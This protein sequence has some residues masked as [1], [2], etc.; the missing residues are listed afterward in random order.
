MTRSGEHFGL[1]LTKGGSPLTL[2]QLFV[3]IH[4]GFRPFRAR[5]QHRGRDDFVLEGALPSRVLGRKIKKFGTI[6]G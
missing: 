2:Y 3:G 6:F 5:E 1:Q 4:Q